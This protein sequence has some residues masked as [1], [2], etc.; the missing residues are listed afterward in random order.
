M[1]D[2][3]NL[4]SIITPMYNCEKYVSEMIESVISQSYM[5][6]EL[7]IV[8]D[9]SN[10]NS[11]KIVLEYINK[12]SRIRLIKQDTNLGPA[13]ARNIAIKNS[14]GKYIAFLDSDDI[15]HKDK[16]KIQLTYMVEN[17]ISVSCTSYQIVSEDLTKTYGDFIVPK[18]ID[19]KSM[20]KRNY[21]SCDTVI[22]D[23]EK[24]KDIYMETF[25]KHEDYITWLKII[26]QVDIAH[27]IDN[28]LAY[29]R[30]GA[31]TR[32]SSKMANIIPLFKVY[33][34][35]EKLGLFKSTYYLIY[36]C[37]KTLEKYRDKIINR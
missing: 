8:D 5:N 32:S 12:D 27:G 7:I 17:N 18:Y 22:I 4:V 11:C 29:Y 21:F 34:N 3:K 2:N 25:Q 23:K 10:D 37:L 24:I 28:I 1:I 14:N 33:Y 20:L 19:Y 6:W 13:E 15:W 26:K 31:Q 35:K 9:N 36:Y 30:I 16:L